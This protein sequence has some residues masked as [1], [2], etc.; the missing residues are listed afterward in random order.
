MEIASTTTSVDLGRSILWQYDRA[1][2][3][4]TLFRSMGILV[5]TSTDDFWQEFMKA[6]M[7][8]DTATGSPSDD[9]PFDGLETLG[10]IIGVPRPTKVVGNAPY[11]ASDDFYRR[12]LKA[13][14]FLSS[15]D[16]SSASIAKY[17]VILFGAKRQID[18]G[19]ENPAVGD[20][21]V[22]GGI[23]YTFI[24]GNAK[25]GEVNEVKIGDSSSDTA[26]NLAAVVNGTD[27]YSTEGGTLI[28]KANPNVSEGGASASGSVVTLEYEYWYAEGERAEANIVIVDNAD[29][30]IDYRIRDVAAFEADSDL[31]EVQD[32]LFPYDQSTGILGGGQV[33]GYTL[34]G[35]KIFGYFDGTTGDWVDNPAFPVLF[36]F[37]AGVSSHVATPSEE[38]SPI[39][40]NETE[41]TGQNRANFV[42]DESQP[43]GSP[44]SANGAE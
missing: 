34:S 6:V 39:G 4:I 26:T 43:N 21:V 12:I 3:L 31:A 40:L 19:D 27:G 7:N 24:S 23:T 20:S 35:Q 11:D 37:A 41:D 9:S 22:I 25:Y 8:A 30:T 17:L 13:H 15:A 42:Y 36:P 14:L 32:F 2:N 1:V 5:N 16:A 18:L 10:R 44:Y 38:L 33:K 28:Q 29:M